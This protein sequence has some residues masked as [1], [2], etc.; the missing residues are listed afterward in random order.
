MPQGWEVTAGLG[1]LVL[2]MLTGR[3]PL[4]AAGWAVALPLRL[5]LWVLGQILSGTR[6][7]ILSAL[8][9]V[10]EEAKRWLVLGGWGV[11]LW[12]L[13]WVAEK[14]SAVAAGFLAAAL[15]AWGWLLVRNV[16][17]TLAARMDRV[18]QRAIF[19]RLERLADDLPRQVEGI[20]DAAARG[21]QALPSVRPAPHP[22][23]RFS[24]RIRQRAADAVAGTT[25][26]GGL[27]FEPVIAAPEVPAWMRRGA[28]EARKGFGAGL[29]R[30]RRKR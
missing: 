3:G 10:G 7:A 26:E 11:L 22:T 25:G 28:G 23:E 20:R 17:R 9:L 13:F 5:G 29:G 6:M 2:L 24:A 14:V 21:A 4:W 1:L 8:A 16:R 27:A 30:K 15:L 18:R 12:T 19:G